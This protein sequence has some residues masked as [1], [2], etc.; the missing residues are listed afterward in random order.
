VADALRNEPDLKVDLVDGSPGELTVIVD[1]DQV[2]SKGDSLPQIDDVVRAV[3]QAG[4]A[5][6]TRH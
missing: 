5:A 6:T 1:G 3:K 4:T 2:A